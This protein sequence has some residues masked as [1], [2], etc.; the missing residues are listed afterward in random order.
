M[1]FLKYMLFEIYLQILPSHEV[2]ADFK[3]N[4]YLFKKTVHFSNKYVGTLKFLCKT[5]QDKIT[6]NSY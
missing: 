2:M 5:K 4:T 6:C 1:Y 3:M